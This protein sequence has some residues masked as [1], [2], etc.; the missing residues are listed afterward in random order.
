MRTNNPKIWYRT[1]VNAFYFIQGLIFASWASRIPEIKTFLDMNDAQF[2]GILFCLPLGEICS[3]IPIGYLV[4]RFGSR[5]MLL[6]GALLYPLALVA[7][8][9]APSALHL[10]AILVVFGAAGN[11]TN[12]A[13]NTQAVGVERLY[14]R[15]I[16]G[17]FHGLWSLAGFSGGLTGALM[18]ALNITP[19]V[20]FILIFAAAV[21]AA[22]C[23]QGYALPRDHRTKAA[24]APSHKALLRPSRYILLLG[25]IA[26]SSSICE[27][28]V[29][30]WT[31]IYFDDV[32]RVPKN[33]VR[34]GYIAAMG[35]MTLGRFTVDRFITRFGATR[36][37]QCSGGLLI[38]G[39]V[40]AVSVP[41]LLTSTFGFLLIGAGMSPVIPICYSLAGRSKR[42]LPGIAITTVSTIGF[43]G[44]L[45]GPPMIG[46]L[47]H[48]I[49]LRWALCVIAV[50]GVLILLLTATLRRMRY[51]V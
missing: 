44:F 7:V 40:F 26:M 39:L 3:M 45:A 23:M 24:A 43:L 5:R 46:F 14:R 31:N 28:T 16:M 21:A 1:A 25:L 12:L 47:S 33:L 27:G 48:A 9:F 34:F 42:L 17:S 4:G 38:A 49:S 50:V 8:G 51:E 30:D 15:S 32:L 10:S 19:R 37:L 13:V 41:H 20:H 22:L 36:V 2:G 6:T 11:L 35:S 18:V 29:F